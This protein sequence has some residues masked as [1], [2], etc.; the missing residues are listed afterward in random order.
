VTDWV[1]HG[2]AIHHGDVP[3]AVR[4]GV[5]AD[6]RERRYRVIVATN[7]LAQGVNLPLRTVVIHSCWRTDANGE[8]YRIP[9]RD[10]W[11]IAG[12]AGRAREET[13]GTVIQ[14]VVSDQDVR[15]VN[16]YHANRENVEAI[17]SAIFQMIK[18]LVEGRI[19]AASVAEVIDA[20]VL[21]L[22]VEEA[23]QGD[24]GVFEVLRA[25]LG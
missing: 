14:V 21:A 2:I 4:K 5:E 25:T 19:T 7:T 3:D 13:E 8:R 11:N 23:T 1:T 6:F 20:E 12:R 17:D 16:Y 24:D 15:D 9:A 18:E 22:L 10:Y